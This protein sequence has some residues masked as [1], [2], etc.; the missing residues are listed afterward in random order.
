MQILLSFPQLSPLFWLVFYAAVAALVF[1]C[2]PRPLAWLSREL[3]LADWA[4]SGS[5]RFWFA[6]L[7]ILFAAGAVAALV[8]TAIVLSWSR[9]RELKNLSN[10]G[11]D[12]EVN[13]AGSEDEV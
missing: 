13:L 9:F 4:T 10:D 2:A 3:N 1:A 11:K 7:W 5:S 8:V 12:A 6:A